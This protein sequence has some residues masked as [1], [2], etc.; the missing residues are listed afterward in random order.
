MTS[1]SA[2]TETARPN[3]S[4]RAGVPVKVVVAD[5]LPKSALAILEQFDGWT[6][7]ATSGAPRETLV[8]ELADADALVVR[9][10]TKVTADLMGLAPRLRVIARAGTGVDNVDVEAA[11]ARGIL[12]MNAPGANSISVAEHTMALMLALSRGIARA[13][14]AMKAGKWEK[15]KLVG[16]ELRGK[17][18]GIIGLG[19][20]GREVAR[21]ASVFGMTLVAYDP[22]IAAHAVGDL[23]LTLT[24]L[25][26]VCAQADFLTLHL[27][28]TEETRHLI[29]ADRLSRCRRGV[30]IINTARGELLD[31]QALAA[32]LE[33]GHVAGA[34]LDV[35]AVEP[36]P[37]TSLVGRPNVVATPHIAASTVEAQE[38][39]GLETITAVADYLRHGIVRNAVN[40]PS[41][42]PDDFARLRPH[43][44]LGERLG[45]L[46]AQLAEG[47]LHTIGV[48]YYG[49][50]SEGNTDLIASSVVAGVLNRILSS[51]VTL[52]NA[53]AE[54]ARR[55]IEVVESRSSR[56]RNFTHLMSVKL[57]TDQGEVWAEG[58]VFEHGSPRLVL[59]DG[60][61]IE[62]PLEGTLLVIRNQDRPGVIG[63]VGTILGRHGV[64][65]GSFALG[66]DAGGAIGVVHVEPP[67][68][69]TDAFDE[70]A[71]RALTDVRA[72][73][74]LKQVNLVRV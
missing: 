39:V 56:S 20:I 26:E 65:I 23:D 63:E 13:D 55:G 45:R 38:Q 18:L 69:A 33:S 73:P 52:V 40:F 17:T 32:A 51:Q 1:G 6:V 30:R 61:E 28:V 25:D 12:V 58:T 19:R 70:A 7:R 8:A 10:A 66:R 11:S 49:G 59:L 36:P 21:R 31:E 29:D 35:F 5:D 34:A 16:A 60:I 3:A 72:L 4:D 46:V 44:E 71:A 68:G 67:P 14:A 57:L 62:V 2:S 42:P 53:R 41:L 50:L 54:A 47:R 64:N 37:D 9:S 24:S 15:K 48:R 27:P 22:Y 43:A 74:A